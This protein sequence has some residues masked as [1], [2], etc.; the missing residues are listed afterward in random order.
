M[1]V[2]NNK[3]KSIKKVERSMA[4]PKISKRSVTCNDVK[5]GNTMIT[6][7]FKAE[8]PRSKAKNPLTE[9]Q[10]LKRFK[11]GVPTS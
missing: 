5:K 1:T 7:Y 2:V 8:K 11:E 6:E 3:R 10:K 9:E 4:P